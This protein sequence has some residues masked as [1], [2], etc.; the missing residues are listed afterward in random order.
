MVKAEMFTT[1]TRQLLLVLIV[2]NRSLLISMSVL[3]ATITEI[4]ALTGF[5]TANLYFR[6]IRIEETDRVLSEAGHENVAVWLG[7]GL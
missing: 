1:E 2:T 7:E 3:S 6:P 5:L 4:A